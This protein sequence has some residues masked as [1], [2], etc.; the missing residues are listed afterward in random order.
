MLDAH[1]KID[2]WKMKNSGPVLDLSD[3]EL[4]DVLFDGLV[5]LLRSGQYTDVRT[6]H[7]AMKAEHAQAF[8]EIVSKQRITRFD[9]FGKDNPFTAKIRRLV[10]INWAA[11]KIFGGT[12]Y[13][14]GTL[15]VALFLANLLSQMVSRRAPHLS[16]LWGAAGFVIGALI[17]IGLNMRFQNQIY[18]LKKNDLNTEIDAYDLGR[19]C[20]KEYMPWL[21]WKS[22]RTAAYVGY[23]HAR[24][25]IPSIVTD[26]KEERER[27]KMRP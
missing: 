27:N 6:T 13:S 2:N 16:M 24:A 11:D 12:P 4:D 14:R 1:K 18:N 23:E 26:L 21:H 17:K 15:Q 20:A 7:G 25:N 22:Y 8:V 9:F 5:D 3:E 10:G 19:A